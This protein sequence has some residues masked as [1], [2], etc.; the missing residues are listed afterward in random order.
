MT[1]KRKL[2]NDRKDPPRKRTDLP[3]RFSVGFMELMDGR[4]LLKQRLSRT[5]NGLADDAGG[6]DNLPY[7]RLILCERASFLEEVLRQLEL[8]LVEDPAG[9]G[10]LLGKWAQ[11]C[12]AL[13]GLLK[14]IGMPRSRAGGPQDWLDSIYS[15]DDEDDP[16]NTAEKPPGTPSKGVQGK[17]R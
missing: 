8:K 2:F 4:T 10:E 7:G 17:G 3:E 9:N 6:V 1:K 5:F 16:E 13:N 12:N 11:S 15:E 14:T